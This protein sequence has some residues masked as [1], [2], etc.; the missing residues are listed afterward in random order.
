MV[1]T[2]ISLSVLYSAPLNFLKLQPIFN[3]PQLW[4]RQSH[5]L[6]AET[7]PLLRHKLFSFQTLNL[8]GFCVPFLPFRSLHLLLSSTRWENL[9]TRLLPYGLIS[10]L[11]KLFER[12]I[13][14]CLL[15][16]IESDSHYFS[17]LGQFQ[18]WSAYFGSNSLSFLVHF[19]C[20]KQT[21]VGLSDSPWC[22][23]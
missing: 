9:T 13:L 20:V 5:L 7:P 1:V 15:F 22:M 18:P 21:L 14:S 19:V 16:F 10:C 8:L 2:I 17:L 3:H 12:M 11:S 6:Y 23:T 4:P